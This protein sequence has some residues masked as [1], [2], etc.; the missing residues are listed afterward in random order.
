MPIDVVID[1]GLLVAMGMVSVCLWTIRVALTAR[2]R[3]FAASA[4]AGI[5]AVVFVLV[6][7]SVLES[8]DSP[9]DL[10][11]YAAGVAAGTLLGVF[12]DSRLS[13]G[14]TVFRIIIDGQ[15]DTLAIA[16]RARGWP[17]TMLSAQGLSGRAALLLL[18]VDDTRTRQVTADLRDLAPDALWTTERLQNS[19][20]PALPGGYLQSGHIR[21]TTTGRR[22]NATRGR[23]RPHPV[24]D[25]P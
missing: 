17:I 21:S 9:V 6:F 5:E 24:R 12:A 10:V 11:G 1:T 13:G 4:A 25:Q 3:R 2:G 22:R 15:G 19:N 23:I 18:V 8:L 16:L 7:A 20:C 14:Q